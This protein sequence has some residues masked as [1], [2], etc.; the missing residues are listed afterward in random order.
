MSVR[1][2]VGVF[3]RNVVGEGEGSCDCLLRGLLGVFVSMFWGVF[4]SMFVGI[5]C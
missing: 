4:V 2:F 3:A 1:K 5:I